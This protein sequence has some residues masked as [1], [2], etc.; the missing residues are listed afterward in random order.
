[1]LRSQYGL[2]GQRLATAVRA[3]VTF[4]GMRIVDDCSW[5]RVLENLA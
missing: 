4:S 1:V 5:K 2:T 3:V